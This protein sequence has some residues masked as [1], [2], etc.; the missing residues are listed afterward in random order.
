MDF[1]YYFLW[2]KCAN[3]LLIFIYLG[4][5]FILKNVFVRYRIFG[6]QSSFSTLDMSFNCFLASTVSDKKSDINCIVFILYVM[7][8]FSITFRIFF[9]NLSFSCLIVVAI[10]F[11]S[12]CVYH[13]WNSS[14]FWIFI[15]LYFIKF[16]TFLDIQFFLS[17]LTLHFLGFTLHLCWDS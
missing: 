2:Y 3:I 16:G 17:L 9:E 6:L 13:I 11:D 4:I 8:Y 12:L 5:S 10:R 7:N 15:L 14:N 1:I